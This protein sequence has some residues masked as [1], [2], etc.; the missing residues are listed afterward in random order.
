[1]TTRPVLVEA[2]PGD[3]LVAEALPTAVALAVAVH[4]A[5]AATVA[6]LIGHVPDLKTRALLVT[7]AGLV[8]DDRHLADLLVWTAERRFLRCTNKKCQRVKPAS[9]FYQDAS[10]P[11]RGYRSSWCKACNDRSKRERRAATKPRAPR[12]R[13]R[14]ATKPRITQVCTGQA[15]ATREDRAA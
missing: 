12:R 3:E 4:D 8:P 7:L 15:R 10:R 13:R 2:A 11:S 5:D 14:A 1:M 9:E 6:D